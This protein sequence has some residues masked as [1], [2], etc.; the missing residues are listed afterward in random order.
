M[1]GAGGGDQA[2]RSSQSNH[3]LDGRSTMGR[4]FSLPLQNSRD[5]TPGPGS[6]VGGCADAN[7]LDILRDDPVFKP[8][9]GWLAEPPTA[10]SVVKFAASEKNSSMAE[11]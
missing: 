3:S 10:A 7:D 6:N 9:C 11:Q 2:G 8:A 4:A 5:Q 1:A